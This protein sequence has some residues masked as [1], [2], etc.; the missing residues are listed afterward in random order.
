M[1]CFY[2]T[3]FISQQ[4]ISNLARLNSHLSNTISRHHLDT[5]SVEDLYA[6]SFASELLCLRDQSY[7]LT[8]D[9][10]LNKDDLNDLLSVV[11]CE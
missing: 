1:L 4:L 7:N 9:V 5:V 8:N 2:V 10:V 3:V 11:L 6:V